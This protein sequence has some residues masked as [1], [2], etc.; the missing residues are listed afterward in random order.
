MRIGNFDPH[1]EK[2]NKLREIWGKVKSE[3]KDT[4]ELMLKAFEKF[5]KNKRI[6]KNNRRKTFWKK[7]KNPT[8]GKG[9]CRKN[10]WGGQG[11]R[12]WDYQ[13]Y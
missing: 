12:R 2:I 5:R 11:H 4:I 13:K 3:L 1:Q 8:G 6:K 7:G 9:K 10:P